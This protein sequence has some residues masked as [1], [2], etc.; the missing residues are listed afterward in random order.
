[1]SLS[2]QL[3]ICKKPHLWCS[4]GFW[5][6]LT[7]CSLLLV[8]LSQLKCLIIKIVRSQFRI[9]TILKEFIGIIRQ[10]Y[11]FH[12]KWPVTSETFFTLL[13]RVFTI[14]LSNFGHLLN[15]GHGWNE[16]FWRNNHLSCVQHDMLYFA[17]TWWYISR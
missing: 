5:I 2:R 12:I 6:R 11:I 10:L 3:T 4:T 8:I 14:F 15:I 16:W 9:S 17:N 7:S 13:T 1:M